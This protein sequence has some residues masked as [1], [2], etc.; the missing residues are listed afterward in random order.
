MSVSLHEQ[1]EAA[2][3]LPTLLKQEE[4]LQF[5]RFTNNDA[6]V[7]GAVLDN[8]NWLRRKSNTVNRLQHSSYYTGRLLATKGHK[9]MAQYYYDAP[10]ADFACHGGGF[11]LFIKNVGC[12]GAIVV[13][14][15]KQEDDHAL[16]VESIREMIHN[17]PPLS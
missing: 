9:E 10:N 5:D 6:L 3:L 1:E 15:L 11:P 16:V 2:K 7:I 17:P 12:V 8:E 13:S 14:G 4:E